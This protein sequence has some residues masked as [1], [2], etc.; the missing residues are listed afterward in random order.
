MSANILPATRLHAG[1]ALFKLSRF[2]SSAQLQ[3]ISSLCYGEEKQFFYDKLIE[4]ANIVETMPVTYA[5]DG[6]GNQAILHLHYFTSRPAQ[7]GT[8]Q[9]VIVRLSSYRLL[10]RQIWAMAGSLVISAWWK[11]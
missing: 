5:T 3:A 11:F 1:E 10:A 6:Q 8:S 7:T 9:S 2:I 4:L